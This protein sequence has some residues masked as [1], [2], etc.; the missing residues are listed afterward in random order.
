M[1]ILATGATGF[2]GR[3]LVERLLERGAD[4]TVV[5]LAGAIAR[6]ETRLLPSWQRTAERHGGAIRLATGDVTAPGLFEQPTS[7]RDFDHVFHLAAI[8]DLA[9]DGGRTM[10]VNVG[11]TENVLEWLRSTG[12]DGV[13]HMVSSIAVAGDY[14]GEWTEDH[15]DEGQSHDHPYTLSKFESERRV[16]D[17]TGIRWRVYRPGAI[18]GHS[19]T[20]EIDKVDGLYYYFGLIKRLSRALPAWFPLATTQKSAV[21]S[22]PVDYVA[23]A[24][25]TLGLKEGL[26]HRVF[27]LVDPA[28][29]SFRRLYNR[30]AEASNGPKIKITRAA[31]VARRMLG[32]GGAGELASV[33]FFVEETLADLGV[34]GSAFDAMNSEVTYRCDATL[35]ALEGTGVACP[36]IEDYAEVLWDYWARN[37]DLDRRRDEAAENYLRA[38]R[39]L[40]TGGSSGIGAAFARMCAP[41]GAHVIVVARRE[42]QLQELVDEL[43]ADGHDADYAVA[44]LSDYESIDAL[45]ETVNERWG[46]PDVLINNAGRSI[47]RPLAESLD[48]FHDFQRV[49]RLNYF[50]AVRLTLGFLP[51]W[52]A[53]RAGHVVNVLSAGTPIR[54]PFFGHYQASKAALDAFGDTLAAEHAHEGVQVTAVYMP[55]VKTPMVTATDAYDDTGMWTVEHAGRFL[56]DGIVGRQRRVY[57]ESTQRRAILQ[58]VAPRFMARTLNLLYRM[59]PDQAKAHPD[60][61]PDRM[62]LQRFFG[63][64]HL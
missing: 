9:A 41:L 10:E 2:L 61:G 12:F 14:E 23:D 46:T 54:P 11:G 1:R 8:Y 28:P 37:L 53:R 39:V 21:N 6:A 30:L 51:S 35:S 49:M 33:R 56:L 50:G 44:D 42:A 15:F 47:R 62:L 52:R 25:A 4:V 5:D 40:I 63:R 60:L 45:I 22:V 18:V 38:K 34:P 24:L 32:A 31:R 17:A 36:R 59:S 13:L 43:R 48:R 19:E 55:L 16:R 57:D 29:P 58:V 27:H 26:D 20:G 64:F 7:A 3:F